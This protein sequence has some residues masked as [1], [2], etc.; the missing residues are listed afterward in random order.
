MLNGNDLSVL[1]HEDLLC[2]ALARIIAP[3]DE[4]PE[5]QAEFLRDHLFAPLEGTQESR[6]KAQTE[7]LGAMGITPD[8]VRKMME[9]KEKK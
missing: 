1:G 9:A 4:H 5:K 3:L 7:A 8:Q 2:A 6:E